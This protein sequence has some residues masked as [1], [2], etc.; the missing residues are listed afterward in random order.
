[1]PGIIEMAL[2]F[3]RQL[4]ARDARTIQEMTSRWRVVERTLADAIRD[5]AE[6]IDERQRAGLAVPS[7]QLFT[8]ERYQALLSQTM[9]EVQRYE[10]EVEAEIMA[11]SRTAARLGLTEMQSMLGIGLRAG[12]FNRVPIDTV[13]LMA[14]M[15]A[16][17]G[18]LFG[19]LQRRALTPEAVQGLTDALTNAIALGWGP[20]KT[21]N[22]MR[23]GLADGLQKALVV[24]RD[25]QMRAY[26]M[27]SDEQLQAAASGL[28]ESVIKGKRRVAAKDGRTCAACLLADGEIIPIHEAGFDHTQ[29]RCLFVPVFAD[30]DIVE[31]G[32]RPGQTY[33]R[34][35]PEDRQRALLGKE[36]YELW[37]AGQV[38]LSEMATRTTHPL[39]GNSPAVKT[40]TELQG[41]AA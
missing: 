1:M 31:P 21:A 16:D 22:A 6:E 32:E 13:Q 2:A 10:R 39:W 28:G 40:V 8:M 30:A 23:D 4:L 24:A 37:K 17:G 20:R 18:A 29:G 14:G 36:R 33:F 34:G 7:S 5:L 12:A 27:A 3:K 25:S 9:F 41:T 15:L 38:S 35:L 19:V 26:R 11:A